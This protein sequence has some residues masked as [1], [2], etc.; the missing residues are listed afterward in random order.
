LDLSVA[1]VIEDI[2]VVFDQAACLFDEFRRKKTLEQFDGGG[3]AA[4]RDSGV[5]DS[6]FGKFLLAAFEFLSIAFPLLL[7]RGLDVVE[8]AGCKRSSR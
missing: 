2:E 8:G 1:E 6:L 5:V 4:R 7:E 3:E